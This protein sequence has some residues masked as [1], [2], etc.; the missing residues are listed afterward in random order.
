MSTAVVIFC[1]VLLAYSLLV[2]WLTIGFLATKSFASATDPGQ[3]P[4]SIIVCARNEEKY[5]PRC[6]AGILQQHYDHRFIQLIVVNDASTDNTEAVATSILK[7]SGLDYKILSNATQLGK[8]KSIVRAMEMVKHELVV[9]RDAD[10]YTA[11]QNWLST[12]S[13]YVA[14][15]QTQLL[16]CPV[17]IG[18]NHGL[19][20]ALQAVENNILSLVSCGSAY[21][22]TP[23]L[24][25]GANLAFTRTVFYDT[26]AYSRHLH[27][28]SGD[29]VFFLE[30]VKTLQNA[31]I[32]YL[33]SPQALVFT[34][35]CYSFGDLLRQKIRWA[36]K[37]RFNTS[38][39]NSLTAL[40]AF[41]VNLG[42]LFCLI[43]G[44]AVPQHNSLCLWFVVS[45][46]IVEF[47]LLLIASQLVSNRHL[48]WLSLPVGCVYPLYA[49][50]VAL[51][52]LVVK[53][54]WK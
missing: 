40:L 14:T 49:C 41:A 19:L 4:L 11:S 35:P 36:S 32:H 22:K 1:A 34:Y 51:A 25:S 2:F 37:F 54:V 46:L 43:Y 10:T 23:F 12:I 31:R 3:Q 50:V 9:T 39:L 24:A 8:K 6:L 18:D 20:W 13:A 44:L 21:H 33:K 38:F 27:I 52:S 17:A 47:L 26:G 48:L 7:N 53:P 29:D 30:D 15:N 28:A 45:K 16:I 5:L 42:W